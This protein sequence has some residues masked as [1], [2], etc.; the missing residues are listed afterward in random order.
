MTASNASA[1][2]SLARGNVQGQGPRLAV[3][4][5]VDRRAHTTTGAP[6]LKFQQE[7]LDTVRGTKKSPRPARAASRR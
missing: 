2:P 4:G 7:V 6:E 5:Q 3:T 1:S